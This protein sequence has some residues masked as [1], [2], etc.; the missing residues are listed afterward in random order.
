MDLMI[1]EARMEYGLTQKDLSEITDIPLRTIENWES[2]KR[3]PSQWVEKMVF[4]YLKQYPKNQ[5]GIVTKTKGIYEVNQ[6]KE[7]LLPLTFKYDINKIILYGSYAKGKQE[8]LSD[9]DLVVDGNIKGIKFF[10][11]LEDVSNALIKSVD[12]IHLSQI[13][14]TS[15]IYMNVMKG[16]VLYER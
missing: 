9:I 8:P 5:H 1:K 11:L 3:T 16:I 13:D 15:D 7:A 10:G 6:I 4:S 12:L 2:G 14:Q